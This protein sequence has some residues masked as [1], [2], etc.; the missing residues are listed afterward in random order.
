MNLEMSP[1]AN[2]ALEKLSEMMN[3]SKSEVLRRAIRFTEYMAEA[4]H[5][6]KKIGVVREGSE[7]ETEI[8]G[9]I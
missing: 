6:G 3:V 1:E 5:K 4:Q 2:G 9:L 7:L 8:V